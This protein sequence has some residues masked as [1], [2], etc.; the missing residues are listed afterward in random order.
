MDYIDEL[1]KQYPFI[2]YIDGKYYAFGVNTCAECDGRS[3]LLESR[4]RHFEESF[5]NDVTDQEAWRI[6]NKLSCEASGADR[7][8]LVREKEEFARF[9]F[10]E[11]AMKDLKKQID[12]YRNYWKEHRL[13]QLIN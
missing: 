8:D 6:F 5:E 3:K 13:S 11:D 4:Y 12:R 10:G 1:F 2:Y 7:R 9:N